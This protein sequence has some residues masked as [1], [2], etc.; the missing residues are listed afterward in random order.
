MKDST[1]KAQA[2]K[3]TNSRQSQHLLQSSIVWAQQTHEMDPKLSEPQ[4]LSFEQT[5]PQGTK[6]RAPIGFLNSETHARSVKRLN[7]DN[8]M[9]AYSCS[10]RNQQNPTLK[11]KPGFVAPPPTVISPP[12]IRQYKSHGTGKPTRMSKILLPMELETAISP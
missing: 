7:K 2:S 5:Q 11:K 6:A 10:K 9:I 12:L 4:H 3:D 1:S 8:V